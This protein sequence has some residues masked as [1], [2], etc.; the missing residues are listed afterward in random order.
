M[1]LGGYNLHPQVGEQELAIFDSAMRDYVGVDFKQVAVA[2]KVEEGI[3]YVFLCNGTLV[4]PNPESK[5]YA[6]KIYTLFRHSVAPTVEIKSI[7][8]VDIA[9]LA[10]EK[11]SE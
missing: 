2:S 9:G 1:A 6:V 8:E 3:E 7:R 10:P 4:V 11:A 5:L